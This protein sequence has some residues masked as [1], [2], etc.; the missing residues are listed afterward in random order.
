MC[1]R[2][3]VMW[4]GFDRQIDRSDPD[5]LDLGR[6][7]RVVFEKCLKRGVIISKPKTVF[8]YTTRLLGKPYV[9][10]VKRTTYC[11]FEKFENTQLGQGRRVSSSSGYVDDVI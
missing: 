11:A 2:A 9:A 10:G 3:I 8:G 7:K 4:K 1:F 5:D 6:D